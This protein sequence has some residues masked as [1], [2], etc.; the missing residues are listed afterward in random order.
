LGS[1][2]LPDASTAVA[3]VAPSLTEVVM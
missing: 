2:S 1:S 3:N